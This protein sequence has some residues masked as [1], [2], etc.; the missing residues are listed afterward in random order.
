MEVTESQRA[1]VTELR[2]RI[3]PWRR[4]TIAIDGADGVGKSVLARYLAWELNMP[5]VETDLYI[6]PDVQPPSYR[7]DDLSRVIAE[8]HRLNRPVIVEGV[9]LLDTLDKI[10]IESDFLVLVERDDDH[11]S[12]FLR[13]PLAKYRQKFNPQGCASFRFVSEYVDR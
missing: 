12:G 6:E 1:L 2:R 13:G 3:Y 10:G 7:Y 9:F 4:Y 11:G 8:R 5:A